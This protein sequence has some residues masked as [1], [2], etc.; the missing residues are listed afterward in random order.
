MQK[1]SVK[2]WTIRHIAGTIWFLLL[3]D[4]RVWQGNSREL[5]FVEAEKYGLRRGDFAETPK[6]DFVARARF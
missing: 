1:R 5:A 2:I 3:D 4:Q 6:G